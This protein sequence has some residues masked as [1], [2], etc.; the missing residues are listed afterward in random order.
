V[1][2]SFA[3]LSDHTGYRIAHSRDLLKPLLLHYGIKRFG[4]QGHAFSCSKVGLCAVGIAAIEQSAT[5]KL[6]E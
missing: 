4:Q 5:A 2:A 1:R 6:I 3:K